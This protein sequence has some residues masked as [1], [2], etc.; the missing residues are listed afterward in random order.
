[1]QNSQSWEKLLVRGTLID[2][3]SE[4][5]YE[6][7]E[8]RILVIDGAMGT[9]LQRHK[10]TESDYRGERFAGHPIDLKNNN[11]ALNFT[12]PDLI[13]D[14]HKAYFDAGA[15]IIETNTFNANAVAMLDFD[16]VPL[17]REMNLEAAKIARQAADAVMQADPT[18]TCYV[19]GALGP[20]TRSA[21]VVVNA[22]KPAFRNV[23]FDELYA[24]Y[25]E[26]AQ[27]LLDG[28]V[29]LLLCETTFDTLN[30]K[31]ALLAIQE[32]FDAG[33][34]RVPLSASLTI[35]DIAGGNLSG[36]NLAAM[37]HSIRHA[38]LFSVGLNC[39]L[40]PKEMRP[41]IA[42]LSQSADV[43]VSAYP[44]AGLPDPLSETGFPE[45]PETLAP[46]LR[47]WAES[48]YLNIVGGCCGTTPAHIR[49]IA[50]AVKDLP[51]RPVPKANE[52]MKLSGT[53][54][55][56]R[57]RPD[58]NFVN[59]GERCNVAGSPKFAKLVREGQFEEALTI[60]RQ[61]VVNG[62]QVLDICF[63]DGLLDGETCM[64]HFVNLIQ[65]EP[66]IH[67]VPLMIDSS[68][69]EIIEAGLQMLCRQAHR[70]QY[71]AQGQRRRRGKVY[72]ASPQ[73]TRVRRGGCCDGV[74]RG[75]GQ[76]DTYERK[77]AVCERLVPA[78]R[79]QGQFPAGGY[80]LRPERS[81][82]RNRH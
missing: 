22:D 49:A 46:Q 6:A 21:S 33:A 3:M 12:R 52:W 78:S 47:E 56:T 37:W 10:L 74:R 81:H 50:D 71:L 73:G 58:T 25:K 43:F 20:C 23:T 30:L 32:L 55:F 53:E 41:F 54:P 45:T 62:A 36:Q 39:A 34:R 18:R 77:I 59:I 11:E 5:I 8:R 68:K 70:E 27:A 82:G 14:V 80:Y 40:G 19:A 13:Y 42:E 79:G 2:T 76:A 26:Q 75:T 72:R 17:V 44:N 31:A 57:F 51:P 7:I 28:G 65:A 15:D 66:D 1:M 61:Q 16:M 24:A 29:D 35:T 60:A 69:W 48:G 63:D 9:M 64:T 38:P 67:R 4:T